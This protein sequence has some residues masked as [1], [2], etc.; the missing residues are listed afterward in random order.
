M[1]ARENVQKSYIS[2]SRRKEHVKPSVFSM[3]LA[4]RYIYFITPIPIPF[5]AK[6]SIHIIY[7]HEDIDIKI[8]NH[9]NAETFIN[10]YIYI[11][12][13]ISIC[14]YEYVRIHMFV[15]EEIHV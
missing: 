7:S 15:Y 9:T 12:I 1:N 10:I 8:Y 13:R 11:Y 3:L 5:L 2:F 6:E 4:Y 14:I